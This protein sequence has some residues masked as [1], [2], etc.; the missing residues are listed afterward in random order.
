[1]TTPDTQDSSGTG[2][3][4]VSSK[5]TLLI[6]GASG[7]LTARLLLPG[8]GSLLSSGVE[9]D[10][11]LI[12]SAT[13][14]WDDQRWQSR[15]ADSFASVDAEGR[16]TDAVID[17]ARYL[18]SDV[19][20]PD[21]LRTLI[22]ACEGQL[23]LYF[24]LPPQITAQACQAFTGIELP[25]RT[26]LV[27][28]KP[29]GYDAESAAEL[30]D[31]V[32]QLVPEDQVH[33]VD[34]FN[35]TPAV[36]SLLGIRFAN[37]MVE[38]LLNNR[39]VAS[40]DVVY[41]ESLTL[42]GRAGFYD[43][44][45]ALLDMIQ[46]HMLE[47]MSLFAME[48]VPAVTGEEVRNAKAQVLR[49][50]RIWDDDPVNFSRRARYTA[51]DI[52]GRKVPSYVD[53]D[54]IDASRDTE[55]L[56]ELVLAVDTWRW[57]GVPFRVR[58]GKSVGN[59]RTEITVTFKP[60]QRVPTGLTGG[61]EPDRLRF[62]I[63]LDGN[64]M[65]VDLNITGKG[66]PFKVDAVSMENQFGPGRLPPYGEVLRGVLKSEPGLSVRGDMVVQCWRII[67][68]VRRAWNEDRVPLQEYEA[69]SSGPEGWPLTGLP[70]KRE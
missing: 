34:H 5:Q 30:N 46:S 32:T 4:C 69:G 18:R 8:L 44:T 38:P 25:T 51:G 3:S 20:D 55:T 40:V 15:I 70:S 27:I 6:L 48:P 63:A 49:A 43:K 16:Q 58:S 59:P 33:R 29:F 68:P 41:D 42:E 11:K 66:D 36:L 60:P 65:G 62:G 39:H 35:A 53:E 9:A 47:V 61:V 14:D 21:D 64:F 1:M 10:L 13:Q 56:A 31:L 17:G 52:D 54:G 12:G 37:R 19:T 28:E 24:A 50:T 26:D 7:D 23:I 57:A 22:D 45:G 67:E 2:D